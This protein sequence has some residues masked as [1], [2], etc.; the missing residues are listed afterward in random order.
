MYPKP[1]TI[2]NIKRRERAIGSEADLTPD[3]AGHVVGESQHQGGECDETER[4]RYPWA[5][6]VVASRVVQCE[7]Q[8]AERAECDT[9]VL[10]LGPENLLGQVSAGDFQRIRESPLTRGRTEPD[11]WQGPAHLA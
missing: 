9:H 4:D 1:P 2:L 8:P 11:E 5:Q 10:D 3:Q 6:P 7:S